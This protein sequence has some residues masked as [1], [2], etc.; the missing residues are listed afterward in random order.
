[1]LAAICNAVLL[2][3]AA[4]PTRHIWSRAPALTN[5]IRWHSPRGGHQHIERSLQFECAYRSQLIQQELLQTRQVQG[6]NHPRDCAV[7]IQ[8]AQCLHQQ[9]K[10]WEGATYWVIEHSNL[11]ASAAPHQLYAGPIQGHGVDRNACPVPR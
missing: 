2:C 10:W 11:V 5:N 8:L 3:Y 1:M 9:A 7:Q 4:T 6:A